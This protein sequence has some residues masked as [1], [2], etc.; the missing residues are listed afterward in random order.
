MTTAAL[1]KLEAKHAVCCYVIE[2]SRRHRDLA[3]R[4]L[5]WA[6]HSGLENS[7]RRYR[8]ALTAWRRA[9]NR[10]SATRSNLARRIAAANESAGAP[11]VARSDSDSH[12]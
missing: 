10:L 1:N 8:R 6:E 11:D 5:E 3:K 7:I 9:L 12:R 4:S 2:R